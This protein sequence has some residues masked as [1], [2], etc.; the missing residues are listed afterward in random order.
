M[1]LRKDHYRIES[2]RIEST[3][4]L[5]LEKWFSVRLS[6]PSLS[7]SS[8]C[9]PPERS[10][11]WGWMRWRRRVVGRSESH[12]ADGPRLARTVSSR[13]GYLFPLPALPSQAAGE[14]ESIAASR[15]PPVCSVHHGQCRR[16]RAHVRRRFKEC[17]SPPR[18]AIV[19]YHTRKFHAKKTIPNLEKR[20]AGTLPFP[21]VDVRIRCRYAQ[22]GD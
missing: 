13:P 5:P 7:S 2:N 20:A 3:S 6:G 19:P 9:Y 4:L 1:N 17:F 12:E 10:V 8:S 14:G 21:T 22:T 18:D 15:L 11:W 16:R